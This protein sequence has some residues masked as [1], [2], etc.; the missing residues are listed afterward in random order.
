[1]ELRHLRYFTAVAAHGSFNRAAQVLH[2]TQP[3]LSRQVK[4]LEEEI[5]VPL[6]VR[7]TNSVRLTP[8]G[9]S[10]YEDARELLARA[11]KAV[12]HA[13]G[14]RGTEPVRVGYLPATVHGL[15]TP[16]LERFQTMKPHVRV[17]LVELLPNEIKQ[18]AEA[19]RLD[20]AILPGGNSRDVPGLRWSELRQFTVALVMPADHPLARL[21]RIDPSRLRDLPLVGL[22]RES[23]PGYASNLRARLRAFDVNP[24]FIALI[25]GGLASLL[26]S[27]EASHAAAIL[28][29]SVANTLPRGL[30]VRPFSPTLGSVRLAIGL[31]EDRPN[32]H[33]QEFAGL[34]HDEARRMD[35]ARLKRAGGGS[36]QDSRGSR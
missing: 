26:T 23:F 28:G 4:D 36:R 15:M 24:R 31:R 5:G 33:A 3:A 32:Q 1:M 35:R 16:V 27:L 12:A 25:D 20:V 34:L 8:V 6:L 22:G 11:D 10:F 2:L 21:K 14:G 18:A 29:D 30:V 7:N 17:E 9:E 13:R 19:G